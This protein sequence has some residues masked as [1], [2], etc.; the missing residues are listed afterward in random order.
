MK[1]QYFS[2]DQITIIVQ[3]SLL[4]NIDSYIEQKSN[5]LEY[6]PKLLT[7]LIYFFSRKECVNHFHLNSSCLKNFATISLRL[8]VLSDR[9]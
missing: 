9:I 5:D 6:Y 4:H 7:V 8:K 2:K 3:F 1:T